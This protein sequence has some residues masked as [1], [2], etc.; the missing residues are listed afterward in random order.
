MPLLGQRHTCTASVLRSPGHNLILTA[1]HCI[2]GTGA[3]VLFAP[4][5]HDGRAP[6]GVWT[7][8]RAYVDPSWIIGQDPAHDL[9][10][11]TLR[12]QRRAGHTVNVQ[13]RAGGN[14]L[15]P[16]PAGGTL[17]QVP[18]YPVGINDD[19]I[20]CRDRTYLTTGYPSFDCHFYVDG[21]SGAPFLRAR[22]D[23]S[24]GHGEGD[25]HRQGDGQGDGQ[26]GGHGDAE[27]VVGVIGGLHQGGCVD[28][29]SYSSP[30]GSDTRRLLDRASR[31]L[32]PDVL[33]TPGSAGC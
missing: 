33:P 28:Y 12:P 9:A 21:T 11:L 31:G 10:I 20:N 17:V 23:D 15:G 16:A 5:Y 8:E 24:E 25:S 27:V 26:G 22:D 3:G 19:P 4:G 18:A 13:D 7:A 1:A 32:S 30:F 29:T 6:Y 14:I 2:A